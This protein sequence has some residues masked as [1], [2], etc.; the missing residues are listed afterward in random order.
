MIA[1]SIAVIA[2][3][4]WEAGGVEKVYTANSDSGRL[5]FFQFTGDMTTRVDTTSAWLGQLFM[6]LSLFGCQ[7]NFVQR[8]VSM[9]SLKDVK[10]FVQFNFI[11]QNKKNNEKFLSELF[12]VTSL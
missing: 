1:V 5:K 12:K 6:S 10:R 3:S 4:A 11:Q 7:Q 2:Q 9:K 8:Y